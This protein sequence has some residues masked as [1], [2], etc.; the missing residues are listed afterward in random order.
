LSVYSVEDYSLELIRLAREADVNRILEILEG[1][2]GKGLSKGGNISHT[3][4]EKKSASSLVQM[5]KELFQ[6]NYLL[7]MNYYTIG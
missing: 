3:R 2:K 4:E 5:L 6:E 1:V 7:M